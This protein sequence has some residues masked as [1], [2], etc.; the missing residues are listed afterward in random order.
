MPRTLQKVVRSCTI[1]IAAFASLP[2]AA[3]WS[4]RGEAGVVVS[5]GNTETR[6]GNAKA[7]V[8]FAADPWTHEA[9][10]AAVYAADDVGSTAQRWELSAQTN[11]RFS[12]RDYVFGSVRYED[13][14]FSGFEYQGAASVGAGRKWIDNDVTTFSTQVGVGY[15]FL[16]SRDTFDADGTLLLAGEKDSSTAL[17]GEADFRRVLTASTKVTNKLTVEHTS[18]NTFLQNELALQV[19]M[20]DKLAIALGYAVRYNSDPPPAFENTDTLF[21]ANLVY[22]VK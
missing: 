12:A 8:K 2:A 21:T 14:R 1:L 17:V 6:A 11:Y 5:S 7:L 18:E 22:E 16:R 20:T 4:G 3:Q 15:K 10:F 19:A 13:D 9:G